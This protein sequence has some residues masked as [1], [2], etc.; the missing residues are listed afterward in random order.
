MITKDGQTLTAEEAGARVTFYVKTE[1]HD[2]EPV[3]HAEA[4][5][6][7]KIE[8]AGQLAGGIWKY[9]VTAPDITG[10]TEYFDNFNTT[11]TLTVTHVGTGKVRRGNSASCRRNIM[12]SPSLT[13]PASVIAGI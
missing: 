3:S 5:N 7:F 12:P 6:P 13:I 1:P 4:A 9:T 11:Y 2:L 8:K 10:N